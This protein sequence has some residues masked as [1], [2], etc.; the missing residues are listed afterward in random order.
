MMDDNVFERRRVDDAED[1][2]VRGKWLGDWKGLGEV[3]CRFGAMQLA[4][5]ARF[6]VC[7]GAPPLKFVCLAISLA[8]SKIPSNGRG[9]GLLG[10]LWDVID[11]PVH[12]VLPRGE[13]ELVSCGSSHEQCTVR[14]WRRRTSTLWIEVLVE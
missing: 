7:A 13:D 1:K 14:E 12:V 9:E 8:A 2:R 6:D 4:S 11:E 3:R 5:G 10:G